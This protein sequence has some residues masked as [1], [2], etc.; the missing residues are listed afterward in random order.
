MQIELE[1][2]DESSRPAIFRVAFF[3][4]NDRLLLQYPHCRGLRFYNANGDFAA[5]WGTSVLLS[6]PLDDFVI[7][8]NSRIAF[9]L[10]ATINPQSTTESLWNIFLPNGEYSVKYEHHV[11]RDTD[12]YDFLAKRSRFAG[13]TPIWRGTRESNAVTFTISQGTVNTSKQHPKD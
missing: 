6:V 8:P 9:D 5:E 12:W 4:A 3:G 1:L 11:D 13:K 2:I 10:L 7:T